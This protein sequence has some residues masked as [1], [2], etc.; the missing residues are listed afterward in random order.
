MLSKQIDLLGYLLL[1][2]LVARHATEFRVQSGPVLHRICSCP[3]KIF[4]RNKQE[5][6]LS[7]MT[8][9]DHML[10]LARLTGFVLDEPVL[11][12][13]KASGWR[14]PLFSPSLLTFHPGPSPPS[15]ERDRV[16]QAGFYAS[17]IVSIAWPPLNSAFLSSSHVEDGGSPSGPRSSSKGL[18]SPTGGASLSLT[19]QI[20]SISW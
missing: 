14:K 13:P 17:N 20:L 8:S 2:W 9:E 10:V 19:D 3:W 11:S 18:T 6:G 16:G 12:H 1:I 4:W 15:L 7:L 5:I